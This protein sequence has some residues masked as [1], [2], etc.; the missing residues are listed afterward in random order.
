MARAVL[1]SENRERNVGGRLRRHGDACSRGVEG[2]RAERLPRHSPRLHL[3]AQGEGKGNSA[4]GTAGTTVGAVPAFVAVHDFGTLGFLPGAQL[5]HVTGTVIHAGAAG[6]AMTA[7]EAAGSFPHGLLGREALIEFGKGL[8]A[9]VHGFDFRRSLFIL[10]DAVNIGV[11]HHIGSDVAAHAVAGFDHVV[12]I[13]DKDARRFAGKIGMSGKGGA[14][15]VTHGTGNGGGTGGHVAGGKDALTAGALAGIGLD[16]ATGRQFQTSGIFAEE[17][18]IGLHTHSKDNGIAVKRLF[19]AGHGFKDGLA[20]F[21]KAA[22]SHFKE[23]HALHGVAVHTHGGHGAGIVDDHA[24]LGGKLQIFLGSAHLSGLFKTDDMHGFRAHAAGGKGAVEG[25]AAAA[26]DDDGLA[27]AGGMPESG[28]TQELHGLDGMLRTGDGQAV[29]SG[30]AG[31]HND[32]IGARTDFLKGDVA[33]HA[34]IDAGTHARLQ[35]QTH[36]PVHDIAGQ[37]EVGHAVTGHAAQNG[38]GFVHGHVMAQQSQEIGGGQTGGPAADDGNLLARGRAT[39]EDDL[40]LFGKGGGGAFQRAGVDAAVLMITVA[41]AHAEVR[42]DAAGNAGE[43]ILGA[44]V[45]QGFGKFALFHQRLHLL[46]GITGRTGRFARRR[47]ELFFQGRPQYD[48]A[49]NFTTISRRHD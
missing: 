23:V 35:D 22:G 34:G 7:M 8:G 40:F 18:Q 41:G 11:L 47:A 33:A 13:E 12:V 45:T 14:A 37:A 17:V 46:D 44:Q 29:F 25:H 5:Q 21:V 32:G 24:F 42:A 4:A 26:H 39:M 16:P 30:N 48:G 43:G 28:G 3:H 2:S 15:A 19:A 6:L 9:I 31:G 20:L 27:H 38:F 36:F 10:I 49:R 1:F